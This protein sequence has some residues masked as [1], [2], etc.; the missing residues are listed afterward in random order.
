M[1][2]IPIYNFTKPCL[3]GNRLSIK[4]HKKA[5]KARIKCYKNNLHEKLITS[6]GNVPLKTSELRDKL[7]KLWSP[8]TNWD[9]APLGCG[10][11]EFFIQIKGG[12]Q[13]LECKDIEC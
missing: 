9:L 7:I 10:Y 8:I 4:I 2:G 5:Y 3:K 13:N 11:F 12:S 6:K 1:C